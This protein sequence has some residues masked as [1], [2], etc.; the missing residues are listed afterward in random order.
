VYM[1]ELKYLTCSKIKRKGSCRPLCVKESHL[2][3][4]TEGRKSETLIF[5]LV[6]FSECFF[7]QHHTKVSLIVQ[8]QSLATSLYKLTSRYLRCPF[9]NIITGL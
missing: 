9:L 1:A 8:A 3:Q 6:N 2:Y 4:K 5:N 7:S